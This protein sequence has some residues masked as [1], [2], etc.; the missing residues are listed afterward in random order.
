M[1]GLWGVAAVAATLVS[2]GNAQSIPNTLQPYNDYEGCFQEPASRYRIIDGS[3]FYD[4]TEMT[5]DLC[6]DY[7][8]TRATVYASLIKLDVG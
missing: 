4:S 1:H 3:Y 7:C 6:F 5:V 8:Q 2:L